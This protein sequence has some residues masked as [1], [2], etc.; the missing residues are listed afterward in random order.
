VN[1]SKRVIF[2]T[3]LM[4]VFC[5]TIL[6]WALQDNETFHWYKGNTHT[7]TLNSDGDSAPDDVVRWY[8]KHG[9]RFLV[10]T[11]HDYF[12]N[13]DGLNAMIGAEEQFIV[14][15]GIEASYEVDL[16]SVHINGLNP[17]QYILPQESTSVVET[18]KKNVDAIRS[19][20]GVPHINHP[21]Y[22]WSITADDLKQI[23]N[24]KLFELFSGHPRINNYGGGGLPS[25]EEIWDEVLSS[26]K[27]IYGL[28]VDDAHRYDGEA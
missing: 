11:D 16:K 9:Y 15:K 22:R 18:I 21:N 6:I 3:I 5:G 1:N 7:H 23:T 25:V 27:L 12:T 26:E 19:A 8:R 4:V 28:A 20:G 14:I 10:I 17:A 2:L 24:C 13:V